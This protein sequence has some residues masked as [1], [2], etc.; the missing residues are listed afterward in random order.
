VPARTTLINLLSGVLSRP[1]GRSARG[2][3]DITGL[4]QHARVGAR[5]VRTFQINQL[6]GDLT[7]LET[8]GL[9]VSE[10]NGHGRM[11]GDP[12]AAKPD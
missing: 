2:A 11:F 7:P 9:A 1:P 10:R 8:I 3:E 5:M 4:S 6:F 12:P